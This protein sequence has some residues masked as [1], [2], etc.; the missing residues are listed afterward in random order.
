[1]ESLSSSYRVLAPDSYSSGKSPRWEQDRDITLRDE[2]ELIDSILDEA[3]DNFVLVG[4]SYGAAV[5][6]MAALIDPIRVRAIVVYEPTL[7]SLVDAKQ[8]PPNGADGIRNAVSAAISAVDSGD[9]NTAARYFIDYWTGVGS[10]DAIPESRKPA[11]AESVTNLAGWASAL[12]NEPTPAEDFSALKMPILY[13]LGKSSPESAHA[14]ADAL[15]PNLPNA[16]RLELDGLGHMA[17]IT[18][19][20][21]VNAAI[22]DFLSQLE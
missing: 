13:M 16:K 1:M 4:H 5:A 14:V 19:F 18:H 20:R 3:G 21:E 17:P 9:N 11:I 7:F 15:M 10:W 6:L 12:M 8:P 2:V 22:E